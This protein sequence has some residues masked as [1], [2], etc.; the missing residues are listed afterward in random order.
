MRSIEALYL[1]FSATLAAAGLSMVAFATRAYVNTGRDSMRHLSAGFGLVVA[2]AIGTTVAAFLTGFQN[3]R[4]LLT[5][6]YF[7]TTTGYIFVM[8]SIVVAE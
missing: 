5:V 1:A 2:A 6:N 7:L 8:Y 4:T 3:T